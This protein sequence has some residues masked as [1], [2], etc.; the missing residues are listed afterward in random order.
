MRQTFAWSVTAVIAVSSCLSGQTIHGRGNIALPA[1]PAANVAP[2][3]DNYNGTKITDNYRWLE[4]TQSEATRKFVDDQNAYTARYMEL[5]KIRPQITDDLTAFVQVAKWSIPIQ[6]GDNLYFAKRLAGEDQASIYLRAGWEGKD[7][8]LVDPAQFSKDPNTSITLADVSRDG[9]LIA[10]EVREGG[11]AESTVHFF[12]IKAN[13]ILFD[14]LPSSIH[15][16]IVF[17]PDGKGVY[18]TKTDPKGT[19]LYQHTFGERVFRDVLLF[20]REFRAEELGPADLFTAW[21]TDDARYL[22][23]EISRGVPAERV[24]IVFRDLTKPKSVFDVLTWGIQSRFTP[25]YDHGV[26]Y[27]ETDYQAPNGRILKA[28]PGIMPEAWDKLV[29]ESADPITNFNIV[30]HKIFVTRLHDVKVET[31]IYSLDGK[32]AGSIPYD[33]FGTVSNVLGRTSDRYGFFSFESFAIPPA[34]YRVDTTTGKRDLFAQPK[35]TFDATQYDLKQVFYKSKDGNQIPMFIAG[36]KD[37]KQD[38]SE[39]M[40]MT[41]AGGL[42]HPQTPQ[43]NPMW[44]WWLEQ[45]GWLALP[46]LRGG[47]E[48]GEK[49]HEAGMLQHKQT[50]FDDFYAAADYLNQNKYTSSPHFAIAGRLNGGLL[51]GAAITQHPELFSAALCAAPL[52]DMLRYQ[53]S[54]PEWVTEYGSSEDS[55]QLPY[56]ENYSPY[57]NAKK[58]MAYPAVLFFNGSAD[59]QVDAAHV[60]K[61]A[62]LLQADSSSN[63]PILL[64]I[65]QEDAHSTGSGVDQEIQEDADQLSFLW[66][67]TG[68]PPATRK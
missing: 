35:I 8:R 20:G 62:A 23:V 43:W 38:G 10:Y 32:T 2:V 51:V 17:T 64:H 40:V 56:L 33:T 58:G 36:A 16:S 55:D 57:Q 67:E 42:D 24:D 39:R 59:T 47:G 7:K 53:K 65:A 48:Y 12:D 30:G 49:W 18:Y 34:I 63:R 4:D 5:A 54:N 45:G 50:V 31:S 29:P 11:G 28:D 44:A 1:P 25:R 37:L 68:Q 66:T 15:N 52:L 27:L 60:R 61:M 21:V 19:L 26:W 13:K 22:V 9:N 46:N 3:T 14:D 41:G 6:R